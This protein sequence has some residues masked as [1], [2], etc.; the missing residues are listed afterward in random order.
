VISVGGVV[1]NAVTIAV[2]S[3]PVTVSPTS[4]FTLPG[5]VQSFAGTVANALGGGVIA[6][7]VQEGAAGGTIMGDGTYTAPRTAGAFHVVAKN[8]QNA[9]QNA[10]AT[11]TVLSAASYLILNPAAT[12]AG[13]VLNPA[14][15]LVQSRFPP[16]HFFGVGLTGAF[17]M[18]SIGN[19]ASLGTE[20]SASSNFPPASSLIQ[21]ANGTLYGTAAAGG[22]LGLGSVFTVILTQDSSGNVASTYGLPL[23]SWPRGGLFNGDL[24]FSP[25]SPLVQAADGNLYGTT[26]SGGDSLAPGP[27]A[28]TCHYQSGCGTIFRI[29]LSGKFTLLHSFSGPDGAQPAAALIQTGD[30]NFYGTTSSGGAASLGTVFRMDRSGNVTVLHSFVGPEGS[31]PLAGLVQGNDGFLYGTAS[32]GGSAKCTVPIL[33]GGCGGTVFRISAAGDFALLHAFSGADGN[34]PVAPLIQASDG[35]FYGTTWGGGNLTCGP[36]FSTDNYPYFRQPGC[37]TVFRIDTQGNFTVV[38]AFASLSFGT[39]L[40]DGA[41]PAAGV[42]QGSD[43]NLYGT[44]FYGGTG[45][46]FGS[47]SRFSR[48]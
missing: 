42:I 12:A 41:A 29:D 31:V 18:D 21:A 15:A 8:A 35:N 3:A 30:G 1:S 48:Q 2:A 39:P 32:A 25:Q 9:A 40:Y 27:D 5:G 36:N 45:V 13:T 20:Y 23:Y 14:A 26:Y 46:M 28:V 38:H 11:V 19:V 47:V 34:E 4:A 16:N 24:G 43:G 33:N 6:W 44:T 22:Q 37:G 10:T 7:S 17:E